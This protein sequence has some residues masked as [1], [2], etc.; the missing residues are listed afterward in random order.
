MVLGTLII[1]MHTVWA[2]IHASLIHWGPLLL[3]QTDVAE[4][5]DQNTKTSLLLFL[6][7]LSLVI[8]I[9]A[10]FARWYAISMRRPMKTDFQPTGPRAT[11]HEDDWSRKPL[12]PS[13]DESSAGGKGPE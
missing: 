13:D 2:S 7:G 4:P 1:V 6:L 9:F 10:L 8:P 11:S 5:M 12:V 3:G